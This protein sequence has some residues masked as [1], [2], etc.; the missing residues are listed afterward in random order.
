MSDAQQYVTLI[1]DHDPETS[2]VQNSYIFVISL[3]L[4]MELQ[5]AAVL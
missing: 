2:K 4:S 3:H 1:Q 5:V